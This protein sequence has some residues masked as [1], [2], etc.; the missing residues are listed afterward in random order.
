M[1]LNRKWILVIA[2]VVSM[3][4]AISGTLAYLTAMDTATNTLTV[5]NVS[6]DLQ[7]PSYT[8]NNQTLL[9]GVSIS[10]DPK[11]KNTGST[12]AWVWMKITVP[13]DLMQYIEGWNTNEFTK[14][15]TVSGGNTIVTMKRNAKLA[16]GATTEAAFTKITLPDTLTSMPGSLSARGSVDINVT[17]YAIQGDAATDIDGAISAYNGSQ[18]GAPSAVQVVNSQQEA[19]AAIDSAVPGTTIR[20]ANGVNYGTLTFGDRAD[21]ATVDITDI[22][23]D[24]VGNEVYTKFENITILGAEGATVDAIVF[25]AGKLDNETKWNYLDIK[26]LTIQNVTFSGTK[27][28]INTDV[29][30]NYLSIDGLKLDGCKMTVSSGD[31][32]LVFQSITGYTNLKD[33]TTQQ[34]V[35][36]VGVKN[37]TITGCTVTGAYQVI[38]ARPMQNLT[39]TNNTFSS[40]EARDILLGAVTGTEYS[41]TITISGNK[42][43]GGQERFVR[44]AGIG[45]ATVTITNNT[46][47]EYAGSDN[48]YIKVEDGQNVT[49][50]GNT[51]TATDSTKVL[52]TSPAQSN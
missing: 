8:G 38:E 27:T 28:A 14:T 1:R 48:D 30:G 52:T 29:G 24:A 22:G 12:E 41:G 34:T 46:I 15:E 33:K 47:T 39:I 45:A 21:S 6:I 23:G 26:N 13:T 19:Q 51:A 11:I 40:I 7:E 31:Y 25:D 42:S 49:I 32:R 2:L 9:P 3:V 5:G 50:S 35:M 44:A 18:G 37:L 4:T 16:A 10:K 36:E 20:L 17:A 43:S